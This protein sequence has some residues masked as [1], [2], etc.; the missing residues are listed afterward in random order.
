MRAPRRL[1]TI[2]R[3]NSKKQ[4]SKNLIYLINY[5]KKNHRIIDYQKAAGSRGSFNS[6]HFGHLKL[7]K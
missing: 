1:K 4:T 5:L 3:T 2:L 7:N 6:M